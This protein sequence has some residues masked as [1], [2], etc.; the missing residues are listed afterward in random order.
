MGVKVK[1]LPKRKMNLN[2]RTNVWNG[3]GAVGGKENYAVKYAAF[4]ERKE[5]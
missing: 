1:C 2:C 4:Q 5:D 3:E